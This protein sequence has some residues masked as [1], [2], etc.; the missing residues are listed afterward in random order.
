MEDITVETVS[1]TITTNTAY[2]FDFDQLIKSEVTIA[3]YENG[4][5]RR[6]TTKSYFNSR[7]DLTVEY[8]RIKELKEMI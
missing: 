7:E 1:H 4:T 6:Y 5:Q 2:W 8:F 3:T